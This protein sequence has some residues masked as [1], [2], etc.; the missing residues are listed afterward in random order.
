MNVLD[1]QSTIAVEIPHTALTQFDCTRQLAWIAVVAAAKEAT[2]ML[3][4]ACQSFVAY[5]RGRQPLMR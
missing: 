2:Q 1:R 4:P 5:Q 3:V